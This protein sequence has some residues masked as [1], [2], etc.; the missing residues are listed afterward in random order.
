MDQL[1]EHMFEKSSLEQALLKLSRQGVHQRYSD[2]LDGFDQLASR[3]KHLRQQMQER[4]TL[5]PLLKQLTD[6]VQSLVRRELE[7]LQRE[8]SASEREL[9]EKTESF[10]NRSDKL[11]RKLEEMRAGIRRA[12]AQGCAKL[13]KEFE[14]LF[15][16]KCELEAREKALRQE[17]TSRLAAL[18][19]IPRGPGRAL[20]KLKNYGPRDPSV[21]Q[22]L[23]ELSE[24]A[25]KIASLERAQVQPGFS[26]TESVGLEDGISLVKRLLDM[27]RLEARLKKGALSPADQSILVELLG[28]DALA[29]LDSIVRLK[30]KLMSAGYLDKGDDGLKLSP[31]A[32]RRIGQKALSDIFSKLARGQVGGHQTSYKGAGQPDIAATKA[33]RFG[34]SFNIHLS[35]TL[36]NALVRDAGRVPVDIS[37][38]DFEVFEEQRSGGCS[39]VLMLDLSYTMAQNSKLQAAKKVVFALDSLIRTRFPRDTLHIVGFA[40]YAR[41]L[42]REELPHVTL[43]LGNPFTNIQDGFRLAERLISRYNCKNRQI[44]LITDGEPTA[45][46]RNG[47]LYVDYPPTPE[48]FVETMKEV[49]RLTRK[50]IVINTFMLDSR[51]GLIEFVE[52]MTR[53][54]KGRAFFS[55]PHTLGEYLLVDYLSHRRRVI[56]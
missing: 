29:N 54:N 25:D 12:S 36:M 30:E 23:K 33:Y 28:P 34:D 15:L 24:A 17:E 22:A 2:S 56:N 53:T 1:A 21:G 27:E 38:A 10:V 45:Y 3:L 47:D 42:T 44:I 20:D 6:L 16:D 41:E 48:I 40:T 19:Q 35:R 7:A 52:R 4:Y 46:C 18:Q 26:G 50:G 13:E 51:P 8:I 11:I 14:Q 31:R 32:I 55:S 39:N 9:S 5:D 37:P 49:V 43:T